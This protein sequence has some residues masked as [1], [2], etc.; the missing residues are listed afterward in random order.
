[1]GRQSAL[2]RPRFPLLM[3]VDGHY[4]HR[5]LASETMPMPILKKR[6]LT[7]A[8]VLAF[9]L[10]LA[11]AWFLSKALPIGTGYAAKYICSA[12]FVSGRDPVTTFAED[13]VPVNP[14]ARLIGVAVNRPEKRVRADAFG[15]FA[16]EALYREG[17]GCTL[18]VGTAVDQLRAQPIA[19][20]ATPAPLSADLS[21]PEG[22]GKSVGPLPAGVDA[23]R[24]N[25]ALDRAFAEDSEMGRKNTRAVV[26]VY[27]GRLVA[28]RYAPGVDPAMP[29]LGWSMAKSVTNAL[30]GILVGQGKLALQAPAPV[31][32]WRQPG[33][34]RGRITLDQLLRMSSGLA[35]D[36]R[37]LPL[38][39]AT[40]MLYGSAD[41]AAFAA[42]K[43]LTADP[44]ERWGYS[45]GTANIVSRIVC[46]TVASQDEAYPEFLRRELLEPI[47][48]ASAV[49]EADPAGTFVGSSYMLA[50][51][52]DWAR[53]G[54]LFLQDGLW[55]GRRIL[56]EGWV[57]YTT[58]PTP[59]APKGQYGAMFW[60]NAGNP[61]N[62][63]DRRWPS[64]PTDAY[65]AEGF[66]E[67]KVIVIPS[68]DAVLVRFG[69]TSQRK[70]WNTDA[71]IADV[72]AALP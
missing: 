11:A 25:Q 42:G 14:L 43:P 8:G 32:Q 31:A 15:F 20:A 54:L 30:V 9:G 58:T 19:A 70:A 67:Q 46:Q 6:L 60:L 66:Q 49:L 35:F 64:V 71:F 13:V 61:D 51:A 12:V 39:D 48:M 36:E 47:G 23:G 4:R 21:W 28:E 27:K 5:V 38:A 62:R 44:D 50:T 29:L 37:Y 52:R 34:P 63:A 3:N 40:D 22:N 16:A 57:A 65:A 56:P 41:F 59:M 1:M 45:S 10:L 72:L 55:N 26:V 68:R 2:K 7:T 69:A 18:V 33:D 24:L 53:F 17:C